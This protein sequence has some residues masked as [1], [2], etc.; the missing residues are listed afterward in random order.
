[1]EL[2]GM[3]Q[4]PNNTKAKTNSKADRF[5][6]ENC[7][8]HQKPTKK[9]KKRNKGGRPKKPKIEQMFYVSIEKL[10]LLFKFSQAK[11]KPIPT[12]EF[13]KW[14]IDPIENKLS[15]YERYIV[16]MLWYSG[17]RINELSVT[18]DTQLVGRRLTLKSSKKRDNKIKY[19][20]ITLPKGT[21]E[22][23]IKLQDKGLLKEGYILNI[24]GVNT[25]NKVRTVLRDLSKRLYLNDII[26]NATKQQTTWLS[27][28]M[29][30]RG[31]ATQ[32]F[33]SQS[34]TKDQVASFLGHND[35]RSLPHY[36]P[37]INDSFL[38]IIDEIDKGVIDPISGN[39]PVS[40]LR[41][42]ITESM[43]EVISD[44]QVIRV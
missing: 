6:L 44:Q 20:T 19:R 1:M 39:L 36:L 38:D 10:D 24:D 29:F 23:L 21:K 5:L 13:F 14:L 11:H 27:P 31:R 34:L 16:C 30:R 33:E 8:T 32:L 35:T 40:Q 7:K 15:D 37:E 12:I 25:D 4:K 41:M 2:S 22:L 42:I 43:R 18:E 28:H 26:H 3:T 9:S 17:C